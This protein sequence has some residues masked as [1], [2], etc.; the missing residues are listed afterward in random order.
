M[1]NSLVKSWEITS[2]ARKYFGTQ[3]CEILYE[4]YD[5][6]LTMWKFRTGK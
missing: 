6:E 1:F 3:I 5:V 4:I 2:F